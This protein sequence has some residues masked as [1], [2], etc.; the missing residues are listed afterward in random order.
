MV[1][2]EEQEKKKVIQNQFCMQQIS[3]I[4]AKDYPGGRTAREM[5]KPPASSI[6]W[7]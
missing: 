5:F 1:S 2:A 6:C 3:S 7:I 4:A